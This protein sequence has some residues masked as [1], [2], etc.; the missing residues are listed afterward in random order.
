MPTGQD[1]MLPGGTPAG[2]AKGTPPVDPGG[3]AAVAPPA[4]VAAAAADD[5]DD[6]DADVD[7][8]ISVDGVMLWVPTGCG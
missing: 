4:A 8:G 1:G 3:P 5:D 6:G 7:P 2:K